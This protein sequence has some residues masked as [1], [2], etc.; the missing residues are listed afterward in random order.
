MVVILWGDPERG[1]F[2]KAAEP[3]VL[4]V[5]QLRFIG[6]SGMDVSINNKIG[7]FTI[8]KIKC[9][10]FRDSTGSLFGVGTA[11]EQLTDRETPIAGFESFS[12]LLSE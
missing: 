8:K 9:Q 12:P 6:I 1:Q 11:K 5:F 7:I 3:A 10:F 4:S 2:R